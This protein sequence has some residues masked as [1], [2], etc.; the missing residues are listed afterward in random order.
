MSLWPRVKLML[1]IQVTGKC[2]IYKGL[3]APIGASG[4]PDAAHQ[5][6]AAGHQS[7]PW[8]RVVACTK[9]LSRCAK[10]GA[11]G[12]RADLAVALPD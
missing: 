12:L 3:R 9:L 1:F 2:L 4:R 6:A 11:A 5:V 8:Q 10:A 7:A